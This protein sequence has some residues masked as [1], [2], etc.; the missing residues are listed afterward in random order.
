MKIILMVMIKI[1]W[2]SIFEDT[3]SELIGMV[4]EPY[5]KCNILD[6][7]AEININYN[8]KYKLFIDIEFGFLNECNAWNQVVW[9]ACLETD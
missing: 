4:Y 3:I 6:D 2:L 7:E 1:V 8:Y 5:E 9:F